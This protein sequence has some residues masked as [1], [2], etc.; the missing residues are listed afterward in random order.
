MD[1][2]ESK[3]YGAISTS[4]QFRVV[5]LGSLYARVDREEIWLTK[6]CKEAN[7]GN[8]AQ[9]FHFSYLRQGGARRVMHENQCE[10][11]RGQEP[12]SWTSGPMEECDC[13]RSSNSVVAI[14]SAVSAAA[15][16]SFQ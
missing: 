5:V 12:L 6:W 10:S 8:A 7:S 15:V 4:I 3:P 1:K 11:E 9:R 2:W 14:S 16:L 13:F